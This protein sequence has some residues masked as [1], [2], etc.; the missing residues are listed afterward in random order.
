MIKVKLAEFWYETIFGQRA[1][2]AAHPLSGTLHKALQ[3]WHL[4]FVCRQCCSRAPFG[5]QWSLSRQAYFQCCA[6]P[7]SHPW[8]RRHKVEGKPPL[9]HWW[10]RSALH[11]CSSTSQLPLMTLVCPTFLPVSP[12]APF[13][14]PLETKCQASKRIPCGP[15]P[16]EIW[17]GSP[18]WSSA[19]QV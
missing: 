13:D 12:R 1:S 8:D 17:W 11:L 15:V 10:K 7:P 9:H 2:W 6:L 5:A 16:N 4:G 19:M 18:I 3:V 14:A